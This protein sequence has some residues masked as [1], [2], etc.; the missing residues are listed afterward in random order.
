MNEKPMEKRICIEVCMESM[1]RRQY[2][3]MVEH[4]DSGFRWKA[5]WKKAVESYGGQQVPPT[6]KAGAGAGARRDSGMRKE[7][8][9]K[10]VESVWKATVVNRYHQQRKRLAS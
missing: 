5:W 3:A 7:A 10:V 9:L 2:K 1:A 6:S 8:G 4:V